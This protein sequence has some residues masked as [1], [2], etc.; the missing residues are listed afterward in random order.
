MRKKLLPLLEK[1]FNSQAVN[2]LHELAQLA[3]EEEALTEAFSLDHYEVL[4]KQEGDSVRISAH[5]VLWPFS[6]PAGAV[7]NRALGKRL[8]RRAFAKL[9]P[10]HGQLTLQHTQ[11]ILQLADSGENGKVL[12]LPGAV[13]VRRDEDD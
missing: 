4:V 6:W 8:I 13:D 3:L 11:Q 9:A 1:Q 12:Q 10:V 7:A 5:H 2:H